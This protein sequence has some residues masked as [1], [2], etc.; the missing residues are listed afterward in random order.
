MDAIRGAFWLLRPASVMSSL[1]W[2]RGI[3]SRPFPVRKFVFESVEDSTEAS[4]CGHLGQ[5]DV[6]EFV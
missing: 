4:L 2:E 3:S 6:D 5:N 1:S